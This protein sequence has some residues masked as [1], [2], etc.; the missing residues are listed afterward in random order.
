MRPFRKLAIIFGCI[1]LLISALPT[2][3]QKHLFSHL[4]V[5]NGLPGSSV[6]AI[7]QD[8]DG[9]MWYGTQND[10][11]S[12]YDG[13]RFTNYINKPGKPGSLSG[14]TVSTLLRASDGKLWVGTSRGLN[15]YNPRQDNFD[16]V[17]SQTLTDS[18]IYSIFEDSDKNIWVGTKKGL[19]LLIDKS[20]Y[21]FQLIQALVRNIPMA[22]VFGAYLK[23]KTKTSGSVRRTV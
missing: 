16:K 1:L 12:K 8:A 18:T 4:T 7:A 14:N 5:E 17:P 19:H 21:Q 11:L 20:R 10:G 9:F 2:A 15:I 22:G 23:T 3:A 13:V 6:I